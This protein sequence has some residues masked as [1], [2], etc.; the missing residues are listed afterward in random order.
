[1]SRIDV[2][3][4]DIIQ[5]FVDFSKEKSLNTEQTKFLLDLTK[6]EE[7]IFLTH[8]CRSGGKTYLAAFY[9]AYRI[10]IRDKPISIVVIG[11]TKVQSLK[12]VEYCQRFLQEIPEFKKGLRDRW[13]PAQDC[14]QWKDGSKVIALTGKSEKA[15]R[16]PHGSV[17]IYDECIHIAEE[18]LEI[19]RGILTA[20]D[21]GWKIIYLSTP[22]STGTT[23][24]DTML[25]KG[26]EVLKYGWSLDDCDWIP[27]D[28]KTEKKNQLKG[29][30]LYEPEI[31]GS[32][33]VYRLDTRK[34]FPKDL[35]KDNF[36]PSVAYSGGRIGIGVDPNFTGKSQSASRSAAIIVEKL[37]DKNI[38]HAAWDFTYAD[39]V[40]EQVEFVLRLIEDPLGIG[41]PAHEVRVDSGAAQFLGMLS[42]RAR[43]EGLSFQN[44][45]K[46]ESR[47]IQFLPRTYFNV[48]EEA[49]LKHKISKYPKRKPFQSMW[50]V[51]EQLRDYSPDWLSKGHKHD[52]TDGLMLALWEEYKPL[53]TAVK[54]DYDPFD[55]TPYREIKVK[56]KPDLQSLRKL[57]PR[58]DIEIS[59]LPDHMLAKLLKEKKSHDKER[60]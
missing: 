12:L 2:W 15:L 22:S 13:L 30:V 33:A 17:V 10:T 47:T 28:L 58:K 51:I 45:T 24:F 43:C 26:K 40:A 52:F 5:A 49:D 31:L 54:G 59:K 46:L 25:K 42:Q 60:A 39:T 1:M 34:T 20:E 4:K 8:A 6:K 50:S 38:I 23:W 41:I 56:K 37:S 44:R 9:A 57:K 55:L 18:N 11:G 21:E 35:F 48:A 16:G 27:E 29:S 53:P 32:P 36:L 19:S 3:K 7:H 14:I